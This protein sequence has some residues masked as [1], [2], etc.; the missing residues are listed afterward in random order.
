MMRDEIQL[1]KTKK[2]I[3]IPRKNKP[4]QF[5]VPLFLDDQFVGR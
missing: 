4:S 2:L 3:N 5:T 1:F